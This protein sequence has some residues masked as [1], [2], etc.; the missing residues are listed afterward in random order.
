MKKKWQIILGLIF[1]DII[2]VVFIMIKNNNKAYHFKMKKSFSETSNTQFS[3]SKEEIINV[4]CILEKRKYID[5]AYFGFS[6]LDNNTSLYKV[7]EIIQGMKLLNMNIEDCKRKF[8]FVKGINIDTL[9]VLDLVYYVKICSNLHIEYDIE[10]V[11]IA[12]EKYYDTDNDLF[13]MN[14]KADSLNV[15]IVLTAMCIENIPKLKG[16]S[17]YNL[18][19]GIRKAYIAY[20]FKTEE[21]TTF[22]NSGADI[23][24][25]YNVIGELDHKII[26]AHKSWFHYWK[27][28]YEDIELDSF[29]SALAYAEFYNIAKLFEQNYSNS[30]L[31]DF[32]QSCTSVEK[33]YEENIL[34]IVNALQGVRNFNNK[35]FNNS[36]KKLII[37][38]LH[39]ENLFNKELDIQETVYGIIL[40]K[41]ASYKYDAEKLQNYI[42]DNYDQIEKLNNEIKRANYLYYNVILDEL[43]NNH[44]VSC[45]Q[46]FL[47]KYV[48]CVLDKMN[49]NRATDSEINAIRK[50]IELVMD[51]QIHN[52]DISITN[53]QRNRI[54]KLVAEIDDSKVVTNSQISIDLYLLGEFL[55][56]DTSRLCTFSDKVNNIIICYQIQT[57][58]EDESPNKYLESFQ[59]VAQSMCINNGIYAEYVEEGK[60]EYTLASILFGNAITKLSY[61]GDKNVI[62]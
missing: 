16:N 9:D 7:N 43:N 19:K 26:K 39:S 11:L 62:N 27:K 37:D 56:L 38:S 28:I 48:D 54:K 12:L 53:R 23:I 44:G 59:K 33:E 24:Y 15:K 55:E 57:C 10:K 52:M 40:S 14:T 17:K 36:L 47:Q 58:L 34:P 46:K 42:N 45:D 41:N 22:Y 6:S 21:N 60:K 29:D 4:K 13:F 3:L 32:Y 1:I 35:R 30:K 61:G 8:N 51:M 50:I 5:D 20:D 49:Y 31:Q 25:C 18:A 2:I